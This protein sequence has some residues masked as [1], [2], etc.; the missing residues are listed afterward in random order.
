MTRRADLPSHNEVH[1]A[2]EQLISQSQSNGPRPSVLALTRQFNLSNT[3]FRRHFPDIAQQLRDARRDGQPPGPTLDGQRQSTLHEAN[4]K[5]RRDNHDL[6]THLEL[7]I[8]NIQ[9]LSLE[10]HQLRQQL[11]TTANV[12]RIDTHHRPSLKQE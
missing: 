6:T 2:A 11:E 4:A 1:Q 12:T 9:R 3:T 5:L 7:A 8:A 10:N